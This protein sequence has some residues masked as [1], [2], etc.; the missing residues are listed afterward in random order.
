MT[1]TAGRDKGSHYLVLAVK[2]ERWLEVVDGRRRTPANPKRKSLK[3]VWVHDAVAE[4]LA[5]RLR[6]GARVTNEEIQS[7]LAALVREEEEVG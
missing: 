1:S 7:A 3:H 5:A 4:G 2:D 6:E